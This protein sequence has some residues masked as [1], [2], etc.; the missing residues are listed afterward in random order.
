MDISSLSD[1]QLVKIPSQS[2]G[3]LFCSFDSVFTLQK[4]FSF[5]RSHLSI[6]YPRIWTFSVLLKKLSPVPMDSWLFSTS[7]R[8]NASVFVLR[9]MIY[10]DLSFE[11]GDKYRS[12]CILLHVDIQLDQHPLLKI[13]PLIFHIVWF[14][15]LCQNPRVHRWVCLFLILQFNL[16]DQCHAC[17]YTTQ[18]LS[19]CDHY[20]SAVQIEIMNSDSSQSCFIVLAISS[21]RIWELL[22]QVL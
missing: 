13:L 2:V 6:V 8:V 21:I 7:M 17:F 18:L 22:F 4:R 15:L 12:I 1:V 20:C 9:S 10:L 19:L 11:Q 5:M 14:W 16:I 3:C